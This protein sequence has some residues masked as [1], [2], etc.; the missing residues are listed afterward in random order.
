[1]LVRLRVLNRRDAQERGLF[2]MSVNVHRR[3]PIPTRELAAL[4]MVW[5][6]A[7]WMAVEILRKLWGDAAPSPYRVLSVAPGR[8]VWR[9]FGVRVG[10]GWELMVMNEAARAPVPAHPGVPAPPG[11]FEP[12]HVKYR[13]MR[14]CIVK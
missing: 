5:A 13:N 8:R 7:A 11:V 9:R 10:G 14:K 3:E 12:V 6:S 2:V 1:M 4:R